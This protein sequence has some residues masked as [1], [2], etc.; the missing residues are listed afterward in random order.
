[1]SIRQRCKPG[2]IAFASHCCFFLSK[3][4][5]LNDMY[6]FGVSFMTTLRAEQ[7]S[8]CATTGSADIAMNPAML[9]ATAASVSQVRLRFAQV[10]MAVPPRSGEPYARNDIVHEGNQIDQGGRA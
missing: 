9:T 10:I 7:K 8:R 3:R 1:M 2:S 5:D 6:R 4:P